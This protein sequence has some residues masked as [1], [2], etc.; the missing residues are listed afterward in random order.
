MRMAFQRTPSIQLSLASRPLD[1]GMSE[2]RFQAICTTRYIIRRLLPFTHV[3]CPYRIPS[4]SVRGIENHQG[5]DTPQPLFIADALLPLSGSTRNI[6][7]K[8]QGRLQT[9]L[10]TVT[11][12]S[13]PP[14]FQAIGTTRC[15]VRMSSIELGC[16]ILAV[17]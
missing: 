14:R 1:A 10:L 11:L 6:F 17:T 4:H 12:Y 16:S 9:A 15:M 8:T 5:R 2:D 7:F 3:E 13:R